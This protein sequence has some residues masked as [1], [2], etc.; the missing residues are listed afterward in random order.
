MNLTDTQN[1]WLGNSICTEICRTNFVVAFGRILLD[2]NGW[3][4][5]KGWIGRLEN[6]AEELFFLVWTKVSRSNHRNS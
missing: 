3:M 5:F 1:L 6:S 2:I 4:D